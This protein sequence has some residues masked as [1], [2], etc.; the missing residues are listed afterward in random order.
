MPKDGLRRLPDHVV[1]LMLRVLMTIP[2]TPDRRLVLRKPEE[3]RPPVHSFEKD[4]D[5]NVL[6]QDS[7]VGRIW[8]FDYSRDSSGERAR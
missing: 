5:F 4:A 6:C 2:R 7:I 3:P 8:R 1:P